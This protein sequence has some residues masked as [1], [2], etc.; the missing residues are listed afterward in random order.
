MFVQQFGL[1]LSLNLKRK[2][3]FL[4]QIIYSISVARLKKIIKSVGCEKTF[5]SDI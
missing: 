3:K 1:K 2:R 5:S 4:V